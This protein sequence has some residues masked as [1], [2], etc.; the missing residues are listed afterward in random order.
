MNLVEMFIKEKYPEV[1]AYDPITIGD[2]N[3]CFV[4]NKGVLNY[5]YITLIEFNEW[6][7]DRRNKILI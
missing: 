1:V 7:V 4:K 5:T 3:I 6:N 2:K